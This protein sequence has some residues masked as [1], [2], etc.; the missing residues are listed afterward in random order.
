VTARS[1]EQLIADKETPETIR[2]ALDAL[3]E[4]EPPTQAWR[5]NLSATRVELLQELATIETQGSL[6]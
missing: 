2:S 1:L 5:T 6:L 4:L 3:D